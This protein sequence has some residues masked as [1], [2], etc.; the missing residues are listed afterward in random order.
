MRELEQMLAELA[1]EIRGE[2][3]RLQAQCLAEY[4]RLQWLFFLGVDQ[5]DQEAPD[6]KAIEA[7]LAALKEYETLPARGFISEKFA[8][9]RIFGTG[10]VLYNA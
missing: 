7:Y 6:G 9:F 4:V 2:G 8:R 10:D 5:Y 3:A 1:G